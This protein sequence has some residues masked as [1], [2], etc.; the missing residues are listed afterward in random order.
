M[1]CKPLIQKC[2]FILLFLFYLVIKLYKKFIKVCVCTCGKKE[3]LY[4]KEFIQ[5]YIKYGVD[6][7]FIY[8]NNDIDGERFNNVLSDY[9]NSGFVKILDWR[10]K[11][12][13]QMP[14]FNH[15]YQ[16]NK[17]IYNYFI[18]FDMDEFIY[19]KDFINIKD[20]L[21]QNHFKKCN[22][23]YFNHVL[24][25]DNEHIQYSNHSLIERFPE[26]ENITRMNHSSKYINVL[27]DVIKSILVGKLNNITFLNPHFLDPNIKNRC[28]GFGE[29]LKQKISIHLQNP[30]YS[31]YYFDHYY[32]KSSQ[33]YITKFSKGNVFFKHVKKFQLYYLYL[34]FAF[35]KITQKKLDFFERQTGLDLGVFRNT[36]GNILYKL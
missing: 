34:Y 16:T 33:E 8:D 36:S 22:I 26:I 13:I 12:Q 32:F 23:I 28:N 1:K 2:I 7:I 18:F 35:N 14:A 11:T 25:T 17:N 9:I 20:Y 24:H 21:S 19:L 31:F 5:H 10:G 29:L 4:A 27:K 6:K 3:N 30:D 15:C